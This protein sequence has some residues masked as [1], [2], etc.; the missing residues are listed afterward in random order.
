MD[1]L[2][3]GLKNLDIDGGGTAIVTIVLVFVVTDDTIGALGLREG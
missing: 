2:A 1:T 3:N